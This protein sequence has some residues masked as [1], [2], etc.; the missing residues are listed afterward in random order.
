MTAMDATAVVHCAVY[1]SKPG[2]ADILTAKDKGFGSKIKL[3]LG[4]LPT[5]AS[6][7][8]PR[9]LKPAA[10]TSAFK[11]VTKHKSTGKFEAHLWD[12]SHIRAMKKQ[13]GR[14]RGKQIYLGGYESEQAAARAYDMAS[15]KFWGDDAATNFPKEQYATEMS[16]NARLSRQE[17]VAKLKRNSTGFS[18]GQSR[19][20]GVTRHH[21]QGKWEA[22]IGRIDGNKYI[23]LGT[24]ASEKEAARAYDTAA[25][26][27][28]GK[29]AVTNFGLGRTADEVDAYE[30]SSRA[31]NHATRSATSSS[32]S[33][34]HDTISHSA[35]SPVAGVAVSQHAA[36]WSCSSM[37][38]GRSHILPPA[39]VSRQGTGPV[40]QVQ[41]CSNSQETWQPGAPCTA[42]RTECLHSQHD[43]S[44]QQHI[45]SCLEYVGSQYPQHS[46][47]LP[48]EPGSNAIADSSS[49]DIASNAA[50]VME[51]VAI[52]SIATLDDDLFEG[53]SWDSTC[54]DMQP[55]EH[56]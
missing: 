18:R 7:V 56:W 16:E 54:F 45:G 12:S 19:Y 34:G 42:Q 1:S 5:H 6:K 28:R 21:Q 49:E 25:V 36:V 15:L 46:W 9:S 17:V 13:K 35:S 52:L 8:A 2:C 43:V 40:Q 23:Y 14:T 32:H 51:E 50:F 30:I 3:N 48:S 26:Q 31:A 10:S 20:R 24:F 33:V 11:G 4:L 22:R 29:K 55:V 27:Y 38:D 37:T 47:G 39:S 41:Q 53:L 44:R